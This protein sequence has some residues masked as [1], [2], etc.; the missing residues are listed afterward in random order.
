MDENLLFKL[1]LILSGI[2]EHSLS[3]IIVIGS[4]K[5]VIVYNCTYINF[6]F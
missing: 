4:C 6:R 1:K 2:R 3:S 5:H